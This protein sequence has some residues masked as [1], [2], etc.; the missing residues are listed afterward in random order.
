VVSDVYDE[1][2]ETENVT[3]IRHIHRWQTQQVCKDCGCITIVESVGPF[4]EEWAND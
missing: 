4:P 2:F 1:K 3:P